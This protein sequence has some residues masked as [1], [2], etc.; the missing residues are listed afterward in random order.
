MLR[1]DFQKGSGMTRFWHLGLAV[2]ATAVMISA[3]NAQSNESVEIGS[4]QAILARAG[5]RQNVAPPI[6]QG[7]ASHPG[8]K[9]SYSYPVPTT[10]PNP[11]GQNPEPNA[12]GEPNAVGEPNPIEGGCVTENGSCQTTVCDGSAG[13]CGCL[14]Q[15][16]SAKCRCG[17][18]RGL[19]KRL[20][21]RDCDSSDMICDT[22]PW[23]DPDYV[24]RA[25]NS[26]GQP[27]Q[28]KKNAVCG[29]RACGKRA[30]GDPVCG[31]PTCGDPTCGDPVCGDP[32]CGD[33]VCG[34]PA[35][36][37]ERPVGLL[38]RMGWGTSD[39]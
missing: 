10:V 11:P 30:C 33:P 36:G 5:Y 27:C 17:K 9:V 6:D 37:S 3:A 25:I 21:G 39:R 19:L 23:A 34:D 38:S 8:T 14:S 13:D 35:C 26:W 16:G 20:S 29:K 7:L 1:G 22:W 24:E 15:N 28:I 12:G 32:V 2:V 31:D 18:K 4:Y